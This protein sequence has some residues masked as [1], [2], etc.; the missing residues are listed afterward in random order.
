MA[1][2]KFDSASAFLTYPQ[3]DL[4]HVAI[5]DHLR[6]VGDIAWARVCSE[7][8]EDGSPHRHV[9]VKFTRRVQSRNSRLF[10]IN[11]KHPN[12]QSVRSIK[13]ALDYVSKDGEFSDVGPVPAG[14]DEGLLMAIAIFTV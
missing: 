12:I 11:G 6:T 3:C 2:F 1:A 10:D 9:V 14:T 8:H 5:I 13:R 7:L 4:E